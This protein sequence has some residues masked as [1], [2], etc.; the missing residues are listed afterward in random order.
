MSSDVGIA[1]QLNLQ[2]L[3]ICCGRAVIELLNQDAK[4]EGFIASDDGRARQSCIYLKS[5]RFFFGGGGWCGWFPT[6]KDALL[7]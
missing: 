7:L 1:Y 3:E 2:R 6:T 4:W 5:R